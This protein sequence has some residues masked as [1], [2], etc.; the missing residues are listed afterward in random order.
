MPH[1]TEVSI[2]GGNDFNII[3]IDVDM[4]VL[5]DWRLQEILR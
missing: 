2:A 1:Y 4:P 5:K 3:L